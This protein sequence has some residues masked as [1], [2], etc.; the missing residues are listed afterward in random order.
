MVMNSEWP[1]RLVRNSQSKAHPY[2]LEIGFNAH[3]FTVGAIFNNAFIDAA[4][5][6]FLHQGENPYLKIRDQF[7]AQGLSVQAWEDNWKAF[8]A[9]LNTF[10]NPTIQNALFALVMH[11]DC[12]I[13]KL[14]TFVEFARLHVNSP[15][16]TNKQEKILAKIGFQGISKQLSILSDATGITFDTNSIILSNLIEMELVRNLGMHN[17]WAVTQFYLDRTINSDW[18]IGKLRVITIDELEAWEKVLLDIIRET[19]T[20][21]AEKYVAAPDYISP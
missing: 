21:I 4:M 16:L 5:G 6:I 1:P 13:G 2:P 14:G 17:Q 9:Y 8:E 7:L 19:S 10:S 20:K 11:W 18:Q 12:Y 3:V 15:V